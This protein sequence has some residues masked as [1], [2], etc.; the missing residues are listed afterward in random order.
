MRA[1]APWRPRF[2]RAARVAA[3]DGGGATRH[4]GYSRPASLSER[5]FTEAFLG[6]VAPQISRRLAQALWKALSG[7][8]W[9]IGEDRFVEALAV[10]R[11]GSEQDKLRLAL[12]VAAR[13]T[14]PRDDGRCGRV[15]FF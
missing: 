11:N 14:P 7:D 1:R 10:A 4:Y 2:P 3:A 9:A 13:A 8:Q 15:S 12:L 5:A 6:E